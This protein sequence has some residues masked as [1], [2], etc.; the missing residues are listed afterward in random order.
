MGAT[1]DKQTKDKTTFGQLWDLYK[2]AVIHPRTSYSL[3]SANILA[4]LSYENFGTLARPL[5]GVGQLAYRKWAQ[6]RDQQKKMALG[7]DFI[8]NLGV[9]GINA[10]NEED[11][12]RKFKT[13]LRNEESQ[14][15]FNQQE[16]LDENGNVIMRDR[17]KPTIY[18]RYV[19]TLVR[20]LQ[21]NAAT[22][23]ER[24]ILESPYW[25]SIAL[26]QHT[27]KNDI[28]ALKYLAQVLRARYEVHNKADPRPMEFRN[29]P[30]TL[31]W[32]AGT[33]E[34]W[35]VAHKYN[36]LDDKQLIPSITEYLLNRGKPFDEL[37]NDKGEKTGYFHP[38]IFTQA[39]SGNTNT[40]A[41]DPASDKWFYGG[42]RSG[43]FQ[44]YDKNKRVIP[45]KFLNEEFAKTNNLTKT[46]RELMDRT[47]EEIDPSLYR[48]TDA[49]LQKVIDAGY[50][51]AKEYDKRVPYYLGSFSNPSRDKI[52]YEN[53]NRKN[54]DSTGM[55]DNI[56]FWQEDG[57]LGHF[58][59]GTS[60]DTIVNPYTGNKEEVPYRWTYDALNANIGQSDPKLFGGNGKFSAGN[61]IKWLIKKAGLNEV[62]KIE[63]ETPAGIYGR[64]YIYDI[65]QLQNQRMEL[66]G[67]RYYSYGK[68]E[69]MQKALEAG[70]KALIWGT[71]DNTL[72]VDQNYAKQCGH[73]DTSDQQIEEFYRF[74]KN[75][76]T[77]PYHIDNRTLNYI[78]KEV[79]KDVVKEA[80]RKQMNTYNDFVDGKIKATDVFKDLFVR[81]MINGVPLP[82][83]MP[84]IMPEIKKEQKPGSEYRRITQTQIGPQK[85]SYRMNLVPRD[86]WNKPMKN[87]FQ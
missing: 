23:H 81:D 46:Y 57:A 62:I 67:N 29:N 72:S 4:P 73:V 32:L 79:P 78:I 82:E 70:T 51:Y 15:R 76:Y 7:R 80:I 48:P 71:A 37:L 24:E 49:E 21:H 27:D 84:E 14:W 13:W 74:F 40:F 6:N 10:D 8:N 25:N 41:V 34:L 28:N 36:A 56:G 61:A 30:L 44:L 2:A 22:G 17:K 11:G 75:G 55:G 69:D 50:T 20:G 66:Y 53:M 39:H 64:S 54:R 63:G 35:N 3:P 86:L 47:S 31:G 52:R 65:P 5:I 26:R 77:Q 33:Q 45:D 58:F 87:Y 60:D 1:V 83:I 19:Y 43:Q 59:S 9:I 16:Q 42:K 38:V 85:Q 18:D 12:I 68:P